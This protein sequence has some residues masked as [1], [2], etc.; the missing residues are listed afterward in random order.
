MLIRLTA[1]ERSADDRQNPVNPG[2][3]ACLLVDALSRL[4]GASFPRR[5]AY[6]GAI[7]ACAYVAP[8]FLD[9]GKEV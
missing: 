6:D 8:T 4:V 9:A 1:V 3:Y 7:R 2:P 5:R